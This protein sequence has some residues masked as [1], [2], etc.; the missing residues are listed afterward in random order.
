MKRGGHVARRRRSSRC[1]CDSVQIHP[2]LKRRMRKRE[3][4]GWVPGWPEPSSTTGPLQIQPLSNTLRDMS[5]WTLQG[6]SPMRFVL[7]CTQIKVIME[8]QRGK[9]FSFL[10]LRRQLSSFYPQSNFC[11]MWPRGS[12]AL[13]HKTHPCAALTCPKRS[14]PT[15][16]TCQEIYPSRTDVKLKRLKG[17]F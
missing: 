8:A 7:F 15:H 12:S 5:G 6:D 13:T 1:L 14:G 2:T 3:E 4:A 10:S 11:S 16:Q 9:K 17:C